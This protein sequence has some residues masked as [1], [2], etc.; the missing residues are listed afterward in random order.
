MMMTI[1][2]IQNIGTF[3]WDENSRRPFVFSVPNRETGAEGKGL[4]L[5]KG[6]SCQS[7]TGLN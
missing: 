2:T 6:A 3:V 1:Q 5:F 7:G 4:S